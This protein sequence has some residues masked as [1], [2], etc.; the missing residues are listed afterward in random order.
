M[1]CEVI[2]KSGGKAFFKKAID[3]VRV[4]QCEYC[5]NAVL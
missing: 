4:C 2:F 3:V 1:T 5:G